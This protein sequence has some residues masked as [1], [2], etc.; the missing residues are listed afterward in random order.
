MDIMIYSKKNLYRFS[1]HF[2]MTLGMLVVVIATFAV[3]VWS[4]K[5]IDRA[6]ESWQLSFLLADELRQSSDDLTRMVRTYVVTGDPIYK[7]HYQETLDIL[8]GKKPRPVDYQN[9]Y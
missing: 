5:K 1:R 8:D 3:Y 4:E 2:W 7:Q 6:N 9:I